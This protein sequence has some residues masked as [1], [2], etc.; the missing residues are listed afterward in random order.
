MD[1]EVL[2]NIKEGD[3]KSY[4]A[5]YTGYFRK[6][7]NYGKK[8]TTD[9]GII[10]D[11]I[12]DIFLSFWKNRSNLPAAETINSYLISSF[13]YTLFRKLK[14]SR[15][16]TDFTGGDEPDFSADHFLIRREMDAELRQRFYVAIQALTPR[17]REAI[18]LRFYEGLSYEEIAVIM[19]ITVKATYKIMARSLDALKEML[20]VS[21][22]MLL[23][24]LSR[25][26]QN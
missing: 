16:I 1:H 19:N 18:F 7:Y 20:P 12:Q 26:I 6:L 17:Q 3:F 25:P 5:F 4:S 11:A 9:G 10:E 2:K 24:L 13:R 14:Q 8:F 21:L 15:N 22:A 23:M